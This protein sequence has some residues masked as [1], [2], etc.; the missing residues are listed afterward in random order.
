MEKALRGHSPAR[1]HSTRVNLAKGIGWGLIGGLAGTLV[2]DLLLMGTLSAIGLP[3]FA[4]FSIIGDTIMHL[5]PTSSGRMADVIPLGVTAHYLIGPAI[6]AIFGAAL[7]RIAA[8]RVDMLKKSVIFALLYVE[9]LS[10][11]ILAATPI[12]LKMTASATLQWFSISF[13]MHLVYGAVLG[14]VV[15]YGLRRA[16]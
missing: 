7:A 5:V 14:A 3:A 10:Q 1:D 16:P 2:M 8:N 11:P 6:G 12:L 13:V 9:I 15:N 4:C